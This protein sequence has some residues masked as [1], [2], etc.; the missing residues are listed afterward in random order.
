MI[1]G[2]YSLL[3]YPLSG[4][5]QTGLDQLVETI[6][7]DIG[8]IGA[9]Q[10]FSIIRGQV[11]ANA[12]NGLIVE[13]I[14]ATQVGNNGIFTANDVIAINTWIRSNRFSYFRTLYGNDNG[15]QKTGF[16]NIKD[17]GA[18][19]I[20]QNT[21]LINTVLDGLYHIGFEIQNGVFI[22]EDGKANASVTQVAQWLTQFFTDRA[23]TNTGLDRV[24][25]L[26]LAD[27]GLAQQIPW[28]QVAAGANAANGLN[29]LYQQAIAE[30]KLAEDNFISQADILAINQWI[31]SD[32]NRYQLFVQLH[33]DDN[34]TTE[35]GFHFVQ[36]NGAN[37]V[38][39]GRN[40]VNIVADGLYHIGFAVQ[41]GRFRNEDGNASAT[42]K[43]VADW[44]TY[45]YVDQSDTGTGLDEIVDTIK[46]DQG[47]ARQTS[48]GDIN[49]G[50][51][52]ANGLNH[53]I[54][55][56]IRQTKV[57]A[58]GWITPDDVRLINQ[59]IRTN[60]YDTF[61]ALHGNDENGVETGYHLVQSDGAQTLFL[62]YNLINRVADSIYHIGFNL[63]GFNLLNEDG[64]I[65]VSTVHVASWLN[66]FYG[67]KT[68]VYGS[69]DD[70][71]ITG[72]NRVEHLL[73]GIGNDTIDGGGG[74]D[75]LEG[76]WGNDILNGGDGND[77]LYGYWGNDTLNGG[78][79]SDR[80][81][82]CGNLA[83]GWS[84]FN[85]YDT[86]ADTGLTE[87]DQIVA[88]GDGDVNVDIGFLNFSAASGI[89]II[90]GTGAMGTVRL[91]G[92]EDANLLDFSSTRF[93]GDNIQIDGGYGNDTLIGTNGQDRIIGGFNN[94]QL[95][96]GLGADILTGGPGNDRFI[97]RS[98]AE[99]GQGS[100][101]D[102]IT[103]FTANQDIID[104]SA[105][106]ANTL[107]A[108]DQAFT[109]IGSQ[110]FSGKAG[111]LQ[112]SGGI[113]AGDINGD[114]VGDFRLALDGITSLSVTSIRL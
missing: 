110:A 47:L 92:N 106:D 14:Q 45:F 79:G 12:L 70:D 7:T 72:T 100:A 113:L 19:T 80:Y 18:T 10:Q 95:V 37:T 54:V 91:L 68:I 30:L 43:E 3:N 97:F 53:L 9:S 83:N 59:W 66:Y 51:A 26:I 21:N 17:S 49:A 89:E 77:L 74:N 40:F 64:V 57:D 96:G 52:A 102:R 34:G 111:Q 104:L 2:I 4:K 36:G 16:L 13:A 81:V 56:A 5:T 73:G 87:T 24:T 38:Y 29:S 11:A 48:A 94:D 62:G 25:Q 23:T 58:D 103:D 31:R 82:V 65:N 76:D 107:L 33:G 99:I 15:S 42:V 60:E 109:Y 75:F 6:G 46:L 27:G 101:S 93:V 63:D 112:F 44:F 20:Y 61:L 28:E 78:E 114:G 84:S 71:S 90:D 22:E 35:T 55:D 105:I 39:F 41:N 67:G 85:G 98:V 88:I 108:N 1:N 86:Y 69:D 8:L 32:A 50:A